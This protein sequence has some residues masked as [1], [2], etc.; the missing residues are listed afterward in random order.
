MRT[1]EE[2]LF[3][4]RYDE[5][6]EHVSHCLFPSDAGLTSYV[7]VA[8]LHSKAESD[9]VEL[10]V[11]KEKAEAEVRRLSALLSAGASP[12]KNEREKVADFGCD[13]A[14][15]GFD[16]AHCQCLC[17]EAQDCVPRD[18]VAGQQEHSEAL[19]A[20]IKEVEKCKAKLLAEEI[21][22]QV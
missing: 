14:G 8:Q 3:R 9:Q 1:S 6:G 12:Q 13:F 2:K 16:F 7:V 15:L 18:V 11:E 10:R 17:A 22:H 5:R 20:V 19:K 4:K 21:A